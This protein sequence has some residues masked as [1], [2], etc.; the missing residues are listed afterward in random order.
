[1]DSLYRMVRDMGWNPITSYFSGTNFPVPADHAGESGVNAHAIGLPGGV[2][3]QKYTFGLCQ[4]GAPVGIAA[5][6]RVVMHEFGHQLLYDHVHSPNFGFAHSCGDSLGAILQDPGSQNPDRFLTFPFVPGIIRRHDR[7]VAGGWAWGGS[8]DVG[9]YS[10]EQILSTTLFR[11][12]RS[13]GG[14]SSRLDVQRFA[15]RYLT[16]TILRG[17][18]SLGPAPITPTNSPDVFAT[19]LMNADQGTINFEGHPGGAFHKVIRWG[20]EKQGLYQPTGAP[21]PVTTTGAPPAVDVYIDDGRGGEYPYLEAFWGNQSIINRLA[22]DGVFTHQ[23]PVVGTPNYVYVKVKNRGTQHANNVVVK[24]FHCRPSTG[25]VWPDDW[26]AMTTAELSVAGG[27][28]PAAEAIVG[29][30][31]W[32][33]TEVGHECLLVYANADGDQANAETVNGPI[34]HWRLVP[35]DNNIGQRNV[36]PVAGGGGAQAL[37]RSFERRQFW[38][39]NPY[40][41]TVQASVEVIMPEFLRARGWEVQFLNAGGASFTLGPRANRR[42][43]I[44]LK[45]GAEF[46]A[47]DIPAQAVIQLHTLVEGRVVGGM[48]YQIDPKLKAPANELPA[49]GGN[50]GPRNEAA[51]Q[52]LGTICDEISGD[53]QKVRIKKVVVEIDLKDDCGC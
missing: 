42:M 21:S 39:S 50:Q 16:Y 15:A 18:A 38:V 33:P 27:I 31:E 24:G 17:I 6:R 36:A 26:Q 52:L 37:L 25:L 51:K 41:R 48:H 29:P 35:F 44:R 47:A 4:S 40:A 53:V 46:Q 2:G 20:F 30:F 45:A 9:S 5:V 28:A 1:M 12:Y 23:T 11:I 32:T 22:P 34:P 8:N 13:T 19:A 10:S 14:D 3:L 7:P 49:G 43:L